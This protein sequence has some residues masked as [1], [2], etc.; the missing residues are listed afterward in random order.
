MYV[1]KG[2]CLEERDGTVSNEQGKG[3]SHLHEVLKKNSIAAGEFVYL[4]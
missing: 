4:S 2:E 3:T 1:I